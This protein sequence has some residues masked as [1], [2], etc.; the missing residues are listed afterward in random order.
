MNA[1]PQKKTK[2]SKKMKQFV[3]Y[4][5]LTLM[6]LPGLLYLLINNYLPLAG[7]TLAF[8]NIDLSKGIFASDWNG[9]ENFKY[10]FSSSTTLEITRNTILYNVAFIIINTVF[11]VTIAILLN[12]LTSKKM[13]RL[14]QTVILLPSFISIIIV[15]YLVQ[16]LLNADSGLLNHIL[17][18]LGKETIA[19][20]SE[21][22]YWPVILPIVNL[23]KG[24]GMLT[25]IYFSSII[26]IDGDLYEAA[27]LDG[28]T[29][30]QQ[31]RCITLPLIRPTV[32]MMVLLAAG[33]IFYSDFGL[34]YQVTM[35]SGAL[36]STTN[37]I[38]TYV[39]RSLMKLGD[40]GMSSAAGAYQSIVGFVLVLVSNLI[41]RK[42]DPDSALF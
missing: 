16:A 30:W 21:P 36:F 34:F 35:N 32:I 33:K 6:T 15:A 17:S 26:G 3:K 9:L 28:A 5:P 10:L 42:I 1:V 40:I 11:A 12:E 18:A 39:Y 27:T 4:F 24:F 29:K 31:I 37:T 25:I 22:K 38:D 19:W 7:I 20:Y 41:V 14:S 2:S 8:K 13:L 23:W